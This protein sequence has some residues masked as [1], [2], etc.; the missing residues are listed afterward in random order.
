[1][2]AA[3][4][5]VGRTGRAQGLLPRG[6]RKQAR[7][8]SQSLGSKTLSPGSRDGVSCPWAE[9]L[10][11]GGGQA[12]G[13]EEAGHKFEVKVS[14]VGVSSVLQR[15][16]WGR[17]GACRPLGLCHSP[18]SESSHNRVN[19]PQTVSTGL[20]L[21]TQAGLGLACAWGLLTLT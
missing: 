3:C 19:R 5:P 15:F 9:Q 17:F 12:A 4:P 20:L 6:G 2:T 21:Y 1:M 8:R 13:R 16:R 18:L 14:P 10:A 11:Q 7:S